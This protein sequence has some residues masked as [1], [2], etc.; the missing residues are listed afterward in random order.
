MAAAD[1]FRNVGAVG[2]H[3]RDWYDAASG[4]SAI[5][6]VKAHGQRISAMSLIH[7]LE[8]RVRYTETDQM[9]A[10]SSPRA[11]EWFELGRT[12]WLRAAGLPYSRMEQDG[13]FLPVVEANC[14]YQR[15]VRFDDP[16]VLTTRL[17]QVGRA[18][19]QFDYQACL[20]GDGQ[21]ERVLSGW[22]SHAFVN[23]DGSLARPAA[24]LVRRFRD[25]LAG[26][27]SGEMAGR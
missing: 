8:F 3:S 7:T 17:S 19:I 22:T 9:G 27:H 1:I 2:Q 24:N 4:G 11:L 23:V 25:L 15:R 5:A 16:I 20:V 14:R 18:S 13:V 10:L 12:E 6:A 21:N 26:D